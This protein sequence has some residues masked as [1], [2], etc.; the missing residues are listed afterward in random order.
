MDRKHTY[1]VGDLLKHAAV[2]VAPYALL[3]LERMPDPTWETNL[4]Y[5]VLDTRSGSI[6]VENQLYVDK[7]YTRIA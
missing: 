1:Q 7:N 4:V 5:R 6:Y 2:G 3:V